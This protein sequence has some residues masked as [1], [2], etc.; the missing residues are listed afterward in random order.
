MLGL[1]RLL[2]GVDGLAN[3]LVARMS[4]CLSGAL[5][6]KRVMERPTFEKEKTYFVNRFLC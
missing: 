5:H 6:Q 2:M 1:T 4:F 3:K